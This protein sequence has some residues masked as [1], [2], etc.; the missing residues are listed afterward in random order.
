MVAAKS[1]Y[2][3]GLYAELKERIVRRVRESLGE[4]PGLAEMFVEWTM[5]RISRVLIS[6][7]ANQ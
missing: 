6:K 7:G 4:L 1:W 2:A 3:N 5:K